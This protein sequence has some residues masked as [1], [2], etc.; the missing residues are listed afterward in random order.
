VD[1]NLMST[2]PGLH[3]LGEANFSDHGANRLGASALLSCIFDGLFGGTCI[4]N[5]ISDAQKTAAADAPAGAFEQVE[6]QE[7]ERQNALIQNNNG[8]ENPYKL[9]QEIGREMTDNCTVVRYN[10]RLRKLLDQ[11]QSW[12]ERYARVQLS[13]TG[14]WTNQNLSF[15]RALRDMIIMAEAILVGAL[16]RDESRGAHYKPEFPKR[17]DANW[18]KTTVASFAPDGPRFRY[19]SVDVSLYAPVERKY[20]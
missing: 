14:M 20:D 8:D 3:V 4:K 17:D 2:I 5:Y 10:D 19:D 18:L 11:C 12:K 13:D 15:T 16:Q 9:W 6:R 1:Y 7:H